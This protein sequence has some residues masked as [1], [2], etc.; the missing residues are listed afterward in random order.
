M[1]Y[2]R[3]YLLVLL[4]AIFVCVPFLIIM[5]SDKDSLDLRVVEGGGFVLQTSDGVLS[6]ND[7]LGKTVLIFFGYLSCPDYCPTTM[8]K[9]ADSFDLLSDKEL[10][11]TRALFISV[12]PNRDTLGKLKEYTQYFHQNII[13]ATTNQSSIDDIIKRYGGSYSLNNRSDKDHYSV[14]HSLDILLM[15]TSGEV[16]TKLKS[17]ISPLELSKAI[18]RYL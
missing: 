6:N 12:D 9:I 8:T 16:I 4:L 1:E 3:R 17:N 5:A 10:S 15:T 11:S 2:L 7:L 14:D 18:G 13:G